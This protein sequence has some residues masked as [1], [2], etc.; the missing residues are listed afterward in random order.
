M[1]EHQRIPFKETHV[2]VVMGEVSRLV[3]QVILKKVMY[4]IH[5]T[6]IHIQV[7]ITYTYTHI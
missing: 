4:F 1:E 3:T 2:E 7:H 6:N 5:N